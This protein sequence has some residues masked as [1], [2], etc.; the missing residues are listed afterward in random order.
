MMFHTVGSVETI[1]VREDMNCT[2][3]KKR[4]RKKRK[5]PL[6]KG[7]EEQAAHY[8]KVRLKD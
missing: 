1:D 5:R 4:K 6:N 8:L 7:E 3:G 2:D